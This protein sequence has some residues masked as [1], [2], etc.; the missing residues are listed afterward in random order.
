[1]DFLNINGRLDII[2]LNDI[3]NCLNSIKTKFQNVDIILPKN[4]HYFFK[5]KQKFYSSFFNNL[6]YLLFIHKKHNL[7]SNYEKDNIGKIVI[8]YSLC[9][10][11]DFI[12]NNQK[13]YFKLLFQ[14]LIFLCNSN[15]LDF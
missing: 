7:Q 8:K 10:F 1:M 4:E 6:F 2:N 15:C 3:Q 5:I 9:L 11:K 12:N 14:G 13:Y